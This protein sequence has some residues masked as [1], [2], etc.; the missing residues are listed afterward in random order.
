MDDQFH[1]TDLGEASY[2]MAIGHPC[3][4]ICP[5]DGQP[6]RYRFCF[7]SEAARVVEDFYR[8]AKVEAQRLLL[9]EREL[10]GRLFRARR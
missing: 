2:L 6:G 8:G 1:T 9:I 10:K 3:L 4:D 5:I 7:A